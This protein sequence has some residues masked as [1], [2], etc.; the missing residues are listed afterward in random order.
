MI[1]QQVEIYVHLIKQIDASFI[2]C[3]N[4]QNIRLK[5]NIQGSKFNKSS[6]DALSTSQCLAQTIAGHL[7]I[8]QYVNNKI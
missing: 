4:Q 5:S 7:L 8:E 6:H 3:K 2:T 1:S